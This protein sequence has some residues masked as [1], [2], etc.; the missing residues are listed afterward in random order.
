VYF[1]KVKLAA[2]ELA[3]RYPE[4]ASVAGT[5]RAAQQGELAPM[6]WGADQ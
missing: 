1:A 3:A 4:L 5:Q 6:I 2:P